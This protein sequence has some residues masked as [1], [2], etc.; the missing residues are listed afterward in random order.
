MFL[1]SSCSCLRSIHWSQVLSWEWRCSWS[2]ADRRCSNYIWVINNCIAYKG[3]TYIRGF[4]VQ[5]TGDELLNMKKKCWFLANA[6][7]SVGIVLLILNVILPTESMDFQLL[8]NQS[9]GWTG[10]VSNNPG[11]VLKFSPFTGIPGTHM[12]W[13]VFGICLKKFLNKQSSGRRFGI[14]MWRHVNETKGGYRYD[15]KVSIVR[16]SQWYI[17]I[18]VWQSPSYSLTWMNY[19]L[20]MSF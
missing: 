11:A 17:N 5:T 20:L 12:L 2:S 19:N 3:A 6:I 14:L 18:H 16:R 10:V 13:C 8:G 15:S 9:H 7:F 1:V 4:T